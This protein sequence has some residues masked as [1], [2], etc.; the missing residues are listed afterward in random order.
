M[1]QHTTDMHKNVGKI[2]L[3]VKKTNS[4]NAACMKCDLLCATLHSYLA[5]VVGAG[6]GLTCRGC[7]GRFQDIASFRSAALRVSLQHLHQICYE[8]IVLQC[9]HTLFRQ[10][11]GLSTYWAGQSQRL[12]GDVVL[13]TPTQKDKEKTYITE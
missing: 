13:E 1:E 3:E 11:G 2:C 4:F 5:F 10:D 6:E 8:E 9:R 12:W 7:T